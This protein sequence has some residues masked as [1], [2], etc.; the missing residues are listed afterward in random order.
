[1]YSFNLQKV[2]A[3]LSE[4]AIENHNTVHLFTPQNIEK[5]VTELFLDNKFVDNYMA[6]ICPTVQK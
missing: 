1:M 5:L 4:N 3:C 2:A 6:G